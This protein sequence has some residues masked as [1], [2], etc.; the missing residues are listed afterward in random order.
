MLQTKVFCKKF[1]MLVFSTSLMLLLIVAYS[2]NVVAQSTTS[3]STCNENYY[4]CRINNPQCTDEKVQRCRQQGGEESQC[5]NNRPQFEAECAESCYQTFTSCW[6]SCSPRSSEPPPRDYP[7]GDCPRPT[8][9]FTLDDNGIVTA[10]AYSGVPGFD[11]QI[12]FYIDG[13]QVSPTSF[14]SPNIYTLDIPQYWRDGEEHTLEVYAETFCN[15]RYFSEPLGSVTF[16]LYSFIF[17]P[18]ANSTVLFNQ[19]FLHPTVVR[20]IRFC[21]SSQG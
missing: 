11:H 9:G 4:N 20:E 13:N 10:W 12:V 19:W 18:M 3:C 14:T 21:Q 15:R 8:G 16:Q 6:G 7:S 5:E 2:Q 17:E 1:L